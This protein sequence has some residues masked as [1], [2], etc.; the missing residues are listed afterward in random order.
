MSNGWTAFII[1]LT[2]AN[3]AACWWLI[4]WTGRS[5]PGEP[6][7]SE[8][9]GHVWDT[10]I[11][12]YNKPLPRWWL[13]LFYGSIV[14]SL[15]YLALYPGLG[16]FA[17]LLEWSQVKSY[18]AE[19]QQ[20]EA[21]YGPLYAGYGQIE[22]TELAKNAEAMRTAGRLFGNNCAGCHGSDGRGAPG[23]PNLTDQAWLYGG[24]PQTIQTSILNGRNGVMPALGTALGPD[25]LE[26]V[27]NYVYGLN[28]RTPAKPELIE[29]GKQRFLMFCTG[30]H[31]LEAKGNPIM[32][33]P[34]LTDSDWLYGSSTEALE[35]TLMQ[36]RQGRM[37]GH[38]ER[39][40]VDRVHLLAAYVYGLPN[41]RSAPP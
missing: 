8:T 2:L 3:I 21:T 16:S 40:G 23:F 14:F 28:G 25:G 29:Q 34:D 4:H 1:V 10:D 15:I 9:T 24:D 37:P 31:G 12:E 5:Q 18:Q 17:G 33:A 20:A 41:Q 39:L 19:I 36:G 30:C 32:G 35:Q 11:K 13:Y 22:I 27:V 38:Q 26:A 6:G 7:E